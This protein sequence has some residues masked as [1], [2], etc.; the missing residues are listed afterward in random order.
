MLESNYHT[1]S[2]ENHQSYKSFY[3]F[4]CEVRAYWNNPYED[5]QSAP[6]L[7]M[8]ELL[9]Y[10]FAKICQLLMATVSPVGNSQQ[11]SRNTWKIISLDN[12]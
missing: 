8:M 3:L 4:W 2:G 1:V 5:G 7:N 11:I 10:V 12:I 6:T 9:S